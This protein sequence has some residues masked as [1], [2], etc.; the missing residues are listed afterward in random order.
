M[1]PDSFMEEDGLVK[2]YECAMKLNESG[3]MKYE[4]AIVFN[5]YATF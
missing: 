1:M 3:M 5:E 2:I 4:S